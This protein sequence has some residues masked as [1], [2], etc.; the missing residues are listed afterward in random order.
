MGGGNLAEQGPTER[1]DQHDD[2]QVAQ[3]P[4]DEELLGAHDAREPGDVWSGQAQRGLAQVGDAPR[5]EARRGREHEQE[6]RQPRG[7]RDAQA[8]AQLPC[9]VEDL[10][11]REHERHGNENQQVELVGAVEKV[12]LLVYVRPG[13]KEQKASARTH[14]A[15]LQADE[16]AQAAAAGTAAHLRTPS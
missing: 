4:H 13:G 8:L 12:A 9:Q 2:R 6:V 3:E 11:E 1:G 7:D 14:V 16:R 5:H 10:R 15:P